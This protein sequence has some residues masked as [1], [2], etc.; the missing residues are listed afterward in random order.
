M[1]GPRSGT[2]LAN[3]PSFFFDPATIRGKPQNSAGRPRSRSSCVRNVK[4]APQD[5]VGRVLFE[6]LAAGVPCH[7]RG[8][9]G[10]GDRCVVAHTFDD[11]AQLVVAAAHLFHCEHA[12]LRH[13]ARSSGLPDPRPLRGLEHYV[14]WKLSAVFA[15]PNRFRAAPIFPCARMCRVILGA[16]RMTFTKAGWNETIDG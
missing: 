16:A 1:R 14:D 9:P 3:S 15:D 5:L 2:I 13:R 7:R 6:A 8:P 4:R 12:A 10:R 11:G